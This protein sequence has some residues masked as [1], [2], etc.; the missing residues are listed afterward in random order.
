MPAPRLLASE[1]IKTYHRSAA[2]VLTTSVPNIQYVGRSMTR[3]PSRQAELSVVAVATLLPTFVTLMYFV[4]LARSPAALQQSAYGIGKAI[5]FALPAVWVFLVCREPFRWK[6]PTSAGVWLGLIFGLAVLAAMIGLY[7]LWLK[8]IGYM[9]ASSGVAEQIR[10]K[11]VG[12]GLDSTGKYAALGVF[13]ALAHSAL[14]EY[15]WRW[16]VFGRLQRWISLPAAITISSLGFMLHHVL[17][18]GTFFGYLVP[19]TWVFSLAIAVG[20]AFWAWLYQRSGSLYGPWL[21]HLVVDAAIF[22]VGHDM[23]RQLF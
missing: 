14:E 9:D 12:L 8:P 22:I 10:Q 13:Y 19:A 21:S 20:G 6:R 23:V 5:Q 4:V 2:G 16:F 11:V 15:Y 17:L 1:Q 7:H 18:L 3:P